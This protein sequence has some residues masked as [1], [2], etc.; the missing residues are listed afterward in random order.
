VRYRDARLL[1]QGDKVTCKATGNSYFVKSIEVYRP[2]LP[3]RI[4]CVREDREGDASFF[5]DEVEQGD[6]QQTG[7]LG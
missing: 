5:H 1:K 6:G 3:I 7:N 4:N 2:D